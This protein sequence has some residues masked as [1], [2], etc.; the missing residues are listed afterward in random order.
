M[1]GT[2]SIISFI[3]FL[4]K[5]KDES[6]SN[7]NSSKIQI[8]LKTQAQVLIIDSSSEEYIFDVAYEKNIFPQKKNQFN[9]H[10]RIKLIFF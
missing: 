2:A 5:K 8:L 3:F 9:N 10:I 7:I 1:L 6:N 4:R